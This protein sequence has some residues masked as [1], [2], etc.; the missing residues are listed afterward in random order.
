MTFRPKKWEIALVLLLALFILGVIL[1][2]ASL[3]QVP[4]LQPILT[5][6]TPTALPVAH[7]P[8]V[9]GVQQKTS[10]CQVENGLPDFTCTPG[11]ILADATKEKIC[12]PGYS[13][14]VRNVSESVKKAAYEEYG[15]TTHK[16]GDY[17][18]DHLISLELGGSNDI[19]N[20][21]PEDSRVALG[22][23]QKDKVENYLHDQVC[24]GAITLEQAQALIS[25]KWVEIYQQ[26]QTTSR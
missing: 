4:S 23:H 3:K 5:S 6:P 14:S 13:K 20:L 12:T 21:W 2:Q 17:E 22:S 15:I 16:T 10:G 18:V 24:A 1:L 26:L 9:L 19:S 11:A 8:A 25:Q 7:L